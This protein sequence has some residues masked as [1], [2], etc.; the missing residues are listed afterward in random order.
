MKQNFPISFFIL[1]V[2]GCTNNANDAQLKPSALPV[3]LLNERW[4]A[5]H[6]ITDS[7]CEG[8]LVLRCG[9]D[10]AS[11]SL[12]DFS[13]HEKLYSH[14]GVALTNNGVM[15]VYSN[16]AGDINPDE[17]MRRDHVDSFL[18]PVKNIAAG[19]YR[20]D[21]SNAELEKLKTIITDHHKNKLQ[22]DMNFDL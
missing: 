10:F 12:R 6:T 15:Y 11:A 17:L 9:N 21:F 16:M 5:I 7:L 4:K 19:V 2:F 18:S 20:Y 3:S 22:F 13:Q 1:I 8:D 14:S